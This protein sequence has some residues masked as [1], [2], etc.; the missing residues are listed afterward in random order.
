MKINRM[1]IM[2]LQ[3][4][5]YRIAKALGVPIRPLTKEEEMELAKIADQKNYWL[6]I[7]IVSWM[8]LILTIAT[9]K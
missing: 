4:C 3:M 7:I 5:Q 1:R 8:L 2:R 6:L 9:W